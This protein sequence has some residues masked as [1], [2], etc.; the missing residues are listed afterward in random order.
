MANQ[1]WSGSV[2]GPILGCQ[3]FWSCST[4]LYV[5]A[6]VRSVASDL[7]VYDARYGDAGAALVAIETSRQPSGH[8]READSV[9]LPSARGAKVTCRQPPPGSTVRT[10]TGT[11]GPDTPGV[12]GPG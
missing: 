8:G 9:L 12:S 1:G 5:V 11:G 2:S 6:G 10:I 7:I 4:A 3:R